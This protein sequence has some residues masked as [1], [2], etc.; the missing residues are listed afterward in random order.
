[1]VCRLEQKP[2]CGYLGYEHSKVQGWDCDTQRE[3]RPSVNY[4]GAVGSA[5][6]RSH[7]FPVM[8]EAAHQG[9]GG[10]ESHSLISQPSGFDHKSTSAR[11]GP[12]MQRPGLDSVGGD[13][14]RKENA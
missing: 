8:W 2:A 5:E 13:G 12:Q 7:I 6:V 11:Q 3:R 10:G 4:P 1:M 14:Q 9:W